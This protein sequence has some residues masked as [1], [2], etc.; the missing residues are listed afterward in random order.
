MNERQAGGSSFSC[1]RGGGWGGIWHL[2]YRLLQRK[3][4]IKVQ[5]MLAYHPRK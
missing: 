5:E 3:E 1:A 4:T 2:G